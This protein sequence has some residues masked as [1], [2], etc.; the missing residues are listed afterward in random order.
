[1]VTTEHFLDKT[2]CMNMIRSI[3]NPYRGTE[4]KNVK[5]FMDATKERK[6]P[7][8]LLTSPSASH[9]FYLIPHH[10]PCPVY[11]LLTP[12]FHSL[13][14]PSPSPLP[15]TH[16][17]LHT[18]LPSPP[19][20]RLKIPINRPKIPHIILQHP[21]PLLCNP[22]VRHCDRTLDAT[23]RNGAH[24]KGCDEDVPG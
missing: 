7:S 19:N 5:T 8:I 3:V 10:P 13:H 9:P 23:N 15:S 6:S 12:S 22:K 20:L 17:P 2:S 1:M 16:N 18:R 11:L 24:D 21:S 14:H 4:T